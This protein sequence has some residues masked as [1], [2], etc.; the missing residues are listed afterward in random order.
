MRDRGFGRV[1]TNASS[2][3]VAPIANLAISN[4]LRLAL[5][6]WS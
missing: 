3:V 4:A 6:G 5:V 2:G 1:I